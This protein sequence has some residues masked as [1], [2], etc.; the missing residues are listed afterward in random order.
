MAEPQS[1]IGLTISHY[2]VLEKLGGGGMGVVYKA[3]G[4]L[5]TLNTFRATS[6]GPA[7]C[8]DCTSGIRQGL[9]WLLSCGGT[10]FR[11]GHKG[12]KARIAVQRFEVRIF[13]HVQN[14][15]IG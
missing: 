13:I 2:R 9:F 14:E 15:I 4:Q 5:E 12:V 10:L 7:G 8:R 1:L 11:M 3:Q 6:V